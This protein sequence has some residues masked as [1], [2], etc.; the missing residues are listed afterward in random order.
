IT[1]Y[2]NVLTKFLQL[3]NRFQVV[4]T[5]SLKYVAKSIAEDT[6]KFA[7][8]RGYVSKKKIYFQANRI[9]TFFYLLNDLLKSEVDPDSVEASNIVD[10]YFEPPSNAEIYDDLDPSNVIDTVNVFIDMTLKVDINDEKQ[11]E[12]SYVQ[13]DNRGRVFYPIKG[14]YEST[15]Q[16]SSKRNQTKTKKTST[17]TKP[18]SK[19]PVS[20]ESTEDEEIIRKSKSKPKSKSKRSKR[21]VSEESTEDD[22]SESKKPKLK[23]KGVENVKHNIDAQKELLKKIK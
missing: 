7:T 14:M 23:E 21:P 9:E 22:E 19:R 15:R 16:R 18:K 11:I 3:R 10:S 5:Q 20:E 17:K 6:G 12:P 2:D 1:P 13:G 8:D 4:D